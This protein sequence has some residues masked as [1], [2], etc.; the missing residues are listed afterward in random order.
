MSA[1]LASLRMA[2]RQ[3]RRD[4]V[5]SSLIAMLVAGP[6][7]ATTWTA[8]YLTTENQNGQMHRPLPGEATL[9]ALS[10]PVNPA[11]A[12]QVAAIVEP[13]EGVR[14]VRRA[15]AV[16]DPWNHVDVS[17][18]PD[19]RTAGDELLGGWPQGPAGVV[20]S[21]DVAEALAV[22]IGDAIATGD[23][24]AVVVTGVHPFE[25]ESAWVTPSHPIWA[26]ADWAMEAYGPPA[27]FVGIPG[28]IAGRVGAESQVSASVSPPRTAGRSP[29]VLLAPTIGLFALLATSLVSAAVMA[30]GL[31]RRIRHTG[32]L[33]VTGAGPSHMRLVLATEATVVSTLGVAVG[34]GLGV[35][36]ATRLTA[37][38]ANL[39]L[40]MSQIVLVAVV[41]LLVGPVFGIPAAELAARTPMAAAREGRIPPAS[42]SVRGRKLAGFALVSTSLGGVAQGWITGV[43]APTL[44]LGGFAAGVGVLVAFPLA[45]RLTDRSSRHLPTPIRMA[46]RDLRRN[47]SRSAGTITVT[48]LVVLIPVAVVV[49]MRDYNEAGLPESVLMRT[50][51]P[52]ATVERTALD[53]L[54][55]TFPEAAPLL[56]QIT[57]GPAFPSSSTWWTEI[58]PGQ[59]EEGLGH[60]SNRATVVDPNQLTALGMTRTAALLGEGNAVMVGRWEGAGSWS[61][62]GPRTVTIPLAGSGERSFAFSDGEVLLTEQTAQRW[63]LAV[64]GRPLDDFQDV[65]L[66]G[67]S[68]TRS[69]ATTLA[70]TGVL[71]HGSPRLLGT[72]PPGGNLVMSILLR[73]GGAVRWVALAA[74]SVVVVLV[75]AVIGSL[76]RIDADDEVARAV[77][78]GASPRFRRH[79]LASAQGAVSLTAGL[80]SAAIG[81]VTVFW[82]DLGASGFNGRATGVPWKQLALIS[83]GLPFLISAATWL[84][85]RS[86]PVRPVRRPA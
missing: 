41:G 42:A 82:L 62:K 28:R 44:A 6:M 17:T 63:Q 49:M 81:L 68:P 67:R 48:V 9:Y 56:K 70:M 35:Y 71:A 78:V 45:H 54:V 13:I 53:Q 20:L 60:V 2:L 55:N 19:S 75:A 74:S 50:P 80:I 15:R 51:I 8:I 73:G 37:G 40:E 79:Y 18:V 61:W 23:L 29:D 65:W 57:Y 31:R 14:I 10:M 21:G 43:A 22:G 26:E 12:D 1:L 30:I 59:G 24:G 4:W 64:S 5:R 58:P 72:L 7:A 32:L 52:N 34:C 25:R 69:D 38:F 86:K 46:V 39:R 76:I 11:V 85:V 84:V 47:P 77:A 27:S 36:A 3:V 83:I 16:I 66:L 33:A